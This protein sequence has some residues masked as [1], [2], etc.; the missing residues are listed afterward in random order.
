MKLE[1]KF[2]KF[3][4]VKRKPSNLE[5]PITACESQKDPQFYND[6]STD[7]INDHPKKEILCNDDLGVHIGP[8]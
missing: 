4:F 7:P 3:Y 1:L 8:Y 2:E 5:Q 6:I